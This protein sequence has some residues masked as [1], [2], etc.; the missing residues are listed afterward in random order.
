MA[1]EKKIIETIGTISTVFPYYTKDKSKEE[2]KVLVNI[3][4]L[5]LKNYDDKEVNNAVMLALRECKMP[6]APADIIE[7]ADMLRNPQ[8]KEEIWDLIVK[9]LYKGADLIDCFHFTAIDKNGKTQGENAR[10][11]CEKVYNSLPDI[12][13]SYMG[14]YGRF[15]EMSRYSDNSLNFERTRFLKSANDIQRQI[16]IKTVLSLNPAETKQIEF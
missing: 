2:I 9:A 14:S 10:N 15:L 11:R 5:M 1:T 12:A 13:K 3:W 8:T 7:K 4:S 6:P 16:N